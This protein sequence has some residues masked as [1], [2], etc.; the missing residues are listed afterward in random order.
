[1]TAPENRLY[2]T[3]LPFA[4]ALLADVAF[5]KNATSTVHGKTLQWYRDPDSGLEHPLIASG[6]PDAKRD[7]LNQYLRAQ[8]L[9]ALAARREC[10]AALP[11]EARAALQYR[12]AIIPTLLDDHY[13]SFHLHEENSC[14]APYAADSGITYSL[15]AGRGI[16]LEDLLWPGD[17]PPHPLDD[18]NPADQMARER[19][20]QWLLDT[21]KRLAPEAMRS[22]F[23]QPRHYLYPYFYLTPQGAYIGPL[24]PARAAAHA[25]PA[26]TVIP[27]EQLLQAHPGSGGK[28]ARL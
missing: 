23:Y 18:D 17:S 20:A 4:A 2:A 15:A 28:N 1:M 27:W 21:L 9:N 16:E 25:H 26:G 12:V 14:G 19:R 8:A 11:A 5:Q 13:A 6:Y 22:Y 3:E 7:A 10:L 24:L